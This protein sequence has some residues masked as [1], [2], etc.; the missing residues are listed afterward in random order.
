MYAHGT[1]RDQVNIINTERLLFTLKR[2][3]VTKQT[4]INGFFFLKKKECK[5][6][7]TMEIISLVYVFLFSKYIYAN[8]TIF[9]HFI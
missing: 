5:L 2:K 8:V 1:N 9:I 3:G 7:L 6:D 4:W